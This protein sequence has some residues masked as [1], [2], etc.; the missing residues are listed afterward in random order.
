MFVTI[1]FY[2]AVYPHGAYRQ[3]LVDNWIRG[4]VPDES[5]ECLATIRENEWC[6]FVSLF[7]CFTFFL[8]H[9]SGSLAT[10]G[11]ILSNMKTSMV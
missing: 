8:F 10:I 1:Q 3:S 6:V 5:E 2:G 4:T 7:L 11:G 9:P